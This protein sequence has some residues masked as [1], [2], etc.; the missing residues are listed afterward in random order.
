M[1]PEGADLENWCGFVRLANAMMETAMSELEERLA[2][3]ATKVEKVEQTEAQ[4]Q[5]QAAQGRFQQVAATIE[6]N[7][8]DAEAALARAYDEGEGEDIAKAQRL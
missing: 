4:R 7:V 3:I 1:V 5:Q 6:K 2:Q 8:T